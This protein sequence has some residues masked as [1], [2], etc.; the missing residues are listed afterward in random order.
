MTR[1]LGHAGIPVIVAATEAGSPAFASRYC[2][3]G[4]LLPPFEAGD[5]AAQALVRLG[6][7]LCGALGFPVPLFY[8]DDD[9]LELILRN[10]SRLARCFRF[11]VNDPEVAAALLDKER[12]AEFAAARALPVPRT[13]RWEQL[14]DA[15]GPVL[16]K[17]KVKTGWETTAQAYLPLFGRA[18][19]ARVFR[20]GHQVLGDP[21]VRELRSRLLFQDYVPGED[22][23]LWSF[24]GYA[25]E[26]ARVLA[27][28]T[29]RKL[30]TYPAL[31][32]TSSF[33]ELAHHDE[34]AALGHRIAASAPLKGPFKMDFKYD[35]RRATWYLLEVNARFNLWHYV[36]ARNGVNLPRVAYAHLL[37]GERG[38]A[39]AKFRT[40]YRWLDFRFDYRAY[41]DLARRGELSLW[42]W[43][44][45]LAGSRKLYPVFAWRDPLPFIVRGWRRLAR[46]PRF[47]ARLAR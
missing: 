42:R 26:G 41:R 13:L 10:R 21:A 27:W 7:R 40:D 32:G 39:Q 35:A 46:L 37:R 9:Y 3:A 18:G 8:G 44:A 12:F 19:K 15:A 34:L 22:R 30:R 11:V 29:G 47:I 17:P 14:A 24:H 6:E 23:A 5:A 2:S 45:S 28:F 38:P 31:T 20:D 16:V 1:A 33:L 25:D 4:L 43:M 36:G